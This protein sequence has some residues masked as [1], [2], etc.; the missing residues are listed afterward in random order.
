MTVKQLV[1]SLRRGGLVRGAD[2][3]NLYSLQH[4]VNRMFDDFFD[5]FGLTLWNDAQTRPAV[6]VPRLDVAETEKEIK[7]SA[8]LPGLDEK[9]V[10]VTLDED[11]LTIKGEK[12]SEHDE[13]EGGWRRIERSY[14]TFQRAIALPAKVDR[15]KIVAKFKKGV[16]TVTMP[17]AKEEQAAEKAIPIAVE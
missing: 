17:K 4:E 7:V 15:E 11:V 16:L 13:K 9:D 10:Q 2:E 12:K 3:P 6:Y 8:E 1:P 5:G 14:G